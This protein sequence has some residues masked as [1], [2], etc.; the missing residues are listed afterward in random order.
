[1]KTASECDYTSLVERLGESNK[2]PIF[3]VK[4]LDEL[5]IT[6]PKKFVV[7]GGFSGCF[8][9]TF[10]L[11]M[12]YNNAVFL[13]YNSG[14][15]SLEMEEEE[16][17]TRLLCLHSQHEK[18]GK[19][20]CIVTLQKIYRKSLTKEENDFLLNIVAPDFKDI[21][22]KII[23]SGPG[24]YQEYINGID[25]VILTM[26]NKL[27]QICSNSELDIFFIDYIQLLSRIY[28]EKYVKTSIKDQFQ[29]VGQIARSLKWTTQT[30]GNNRGIS[31]VAL[32]QLNRASYS[33]VK[34]R[35]KKRNVAPSEK[36]DFIYDLTSISESSEIVNASDILLT[37]Y[38]DENIKKGKEVI[39]QLLKNRFGETLEKGERICALPEIA[40][41]GDYYSRDY[42]IDPDYISNLIN[43]KL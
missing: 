26:E 38:Y 28:R 27:S 43:G 19:Y 41:I 2:G 5:P 21:V 7:L 20:N 33:A 31:I 4:P 37:L 30:Y 40:Y 16:I 10:A 32:S 34:E 6:I 12:A 15:L 1:M 14:F 29:I 8:K 13:G 35:L 39:F 36:Y 17:L 9:T 25:S 18:F 23:I 42:Y 24:D 22:G 11:N 3:Y